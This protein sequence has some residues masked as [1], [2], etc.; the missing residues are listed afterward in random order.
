MVGHRAERDVTLP[1]GDS[2]MSGA[3][4]MESAS[5]PPMADG[6]ELDRSRSRLGTGTA[7]PKGG[8]TPMR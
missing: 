7:R 5:P 2:W 8:S 4:S 1:L 3:V 6:S